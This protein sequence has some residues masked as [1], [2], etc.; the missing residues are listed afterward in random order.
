MKLAQF[1]MDQISRLNRRLNLF[2]DVNP[3][4]KLRTKEAL[5]NALKKTCR[6]I[7]S[8]REGPG[9]FSLPPL[10]L[11]TRFI[12][13][14][15]A[16]AH[17]SGIIKTHHVY[18]WNVIR[19][20]EKSHRVPLE[21]AVSV[22]A[23]RAEETI[24]RYRLIDLLGINETLTQ[25]GIL[26]AEP[27]RLRLLRLLDEFPPNLNELFRL[28]DLPNAEKYLLK[29][30][31]AN[32][33]EAVRQS[34]LLR[35]VDRGDKLRKFKIWAAFCDVAARYWEERR[36]RTVQFN[37]EIPSAESVAIEMVTMWLQFLHYPQRSRIT[38]LF[39]PALD[40]TEAEW[41]A[42][43]TMN[44]YRARKKRFAKKTSR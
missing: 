26:G 9:Y 10:D 18:F 39:E 38:H 20:L 27:E 44:L 35:N 11:K 17:I 4:K 14:I 24:A 32:F 6:E 28:T 31:S 1:R 21:Q 23:R 37:S 33:Q 34:E 12:A 19:R 16:L 43:N 8:E 40:P 41:D 42:W 22:V 30:T 5:K 25:Q 36:S 29:H 15:R 13:E 3:P 7:E 2:F